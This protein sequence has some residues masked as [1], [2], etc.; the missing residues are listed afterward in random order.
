MFEKTQK[1]AEDLGTAVTE[2][3]A[4][5]VAFAKAAIVPAISG[6]FTKIATAAQTVAAGVEDG[7]LFAAT[8]RPSDPP[9]ADPL[10]TEDQNVTIRLLRTGGKT[11]EEIASILNV[12]VRTVKMA[13]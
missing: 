6:F 2:E 3:T 4:Q 9:V 7:S 1:A 10:P 11:D 13:V 8:A 12:S 5:A